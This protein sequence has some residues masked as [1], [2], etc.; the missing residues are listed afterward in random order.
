MINNITYSVN[1]GGSVYSVQGVRAG[2]LGLADDHQLV[3][4]IEISDIVTFED[5]R[6]GFEV[7]LNKQ[8]MHH[9]G[10]TKYVLDQYEVEVECENP[11]ETKDIKSSPIISDLEMI[12]NIDLKDQ[13]L[14]SVSNYDASIKEIIFG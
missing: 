6:K 13:K 1:N 7:A 5:F 10:V 8:E 11:S 9:L 3:Q 4:D 14:R 12:S 2:D